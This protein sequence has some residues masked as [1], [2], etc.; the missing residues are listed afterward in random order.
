VGRIRSVKPELPQ[1]PWFATLTDAA[2]RTYYGLLSV[3]DDCGR[4]PADPLFIGGQIFWGRQRPA[5]AITRQLTELERAGIILRY[6]A[7]GGEYLEIVGWSSKGGPLYQQINKEPDERFPAPESFM[8]SPETGP[9]GKGREGK[10][11]DRES[12]PARDSAVPASV[13]SPVPIVSPPTPPREDIARTQPIAK[14]ATAPPIATQPAGYDPVR[15]PMAIGRLAEAIYRR[16]S[17]ALLQIAAELKLPTPL[18][19]PA[20]NP[21]SSER[22]RDARDR[23]REEGADAPAVCDRVVAN[24]IAQAREERSVEWLAEKAFTAGGW[25]TA[26]AWM[27]GAAA[28]RRGPA[29]GDPLPPAPPPPR[30]VPPPPDQPLSPED[31]AEILA[32]AARVGANPEAAAAGLAGRPS[33][34][35]TAALVKRFG[36]GLVPPDTPDAIADEPRKP[37]R[38]KAAT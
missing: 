6:R 30:P 12:S 10:G 29:R 1:Q 26:R 17:D 35:P 34:L 8:T 14:P 13:A 16:V 20:I 33:S 2:A 21:G 24:L 15:D 28:R 11:R 25:R 7:R 19:F 23:V 32:L 5:A 38:R 27:P 9:E 18:P 3:V 37:P 4:C 31:R 22:T 36:D